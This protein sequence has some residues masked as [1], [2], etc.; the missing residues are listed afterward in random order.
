[1]FS[2]IIVLVIVSALWGTASNP[3]RPMSMLRVQ[4]ECRENENYLVQGNNYL[5]DEEYQA[6]ISSYTCAIED[7]RT[8]VEAFVQRSQAYFGLG[9]Y[10]SSISDLTQAIFLEPDNPTYY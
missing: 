9:D 6:A 8:L 10:G 3:S 2:S 4:L 7:E 5:A 1:M